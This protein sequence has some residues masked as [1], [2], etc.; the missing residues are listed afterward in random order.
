MSDFLGAGGYRRQFGQS[1][2]VQEVVEP[3]RVVAAVVPVVGH[4]VLQHFGGQLGGHFHFGD[5]GANAGI[6]NP[7]VAVIA[8]QEQFVG[9]DLLPVH[10]LDGGAVEADIGDVMQAAP[11]GAAA[12]FDADVAHAG[13]IGQVVAPG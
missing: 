6:L 4:N 13:V 10:A 3:L 7:V 11:V 5:A 9:G 2:P 8:A 1:N 12:H